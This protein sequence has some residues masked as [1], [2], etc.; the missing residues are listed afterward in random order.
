MIEVSA[1]TYQL[2]GQGEACIVE[3]SSDK[4]YIACLVEA[5]EAVAIRDAIDAGERPNVTITDSDE[6][7][8]LGCQVWCMYEDLHDEERRE[9]LRDAAISR[10]A[11]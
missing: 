5:P 1:Y 2:I 6:Y 7:V 4:G 3:G 10:G 8:L 11:T 9:R